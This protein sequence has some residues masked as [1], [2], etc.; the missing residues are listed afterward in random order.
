MQNADANKD[1]VPTKTHIQW[2]FDCIN[3]SPHRSY[4]SKQP[5]WITQLS[6]TNCLCTHLWAPSHGLAVVNKVMLLRWHQ[7]RDQPRTHLLNANIC[8]VVPEF[9][10]SLSEFIQDFWNVVHTG[11]WKH[12]IASIATSDA[13]KTSRLKHTDKWARKT[14][15][16]MATILICLSSNRDSN[17]SV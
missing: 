5:G 6:K 8:R 11:C 16:G 17:S 12:E 13:F 14:L 15:C 3:G 9:Q 10:L 7:A 2:S 4:R 1:T